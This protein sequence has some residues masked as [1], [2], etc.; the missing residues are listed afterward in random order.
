MKRTI[1]TIVLGVLAFGSLSVQAGQGDSIVAWGSNTYGQLG[2]GT[3]T[4]RT[5]PV[6]VSGLSGV[7]AIAMGGW[8]SLGLK[9]TCLYKLIGDN[10]NDCK[11]DLLDLA[12]VA[13]NWLIDCDVEP[14][15]PACVPVE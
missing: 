6:A 10:N 5:T 11:V 13:E 3:T 14:S 7:T 4:N 2:D 12:L 9:T 8:H 15:K 1:L